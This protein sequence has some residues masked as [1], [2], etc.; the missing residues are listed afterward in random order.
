[1]FGT[2][3]SQHARVELSIL[4]NAR[5]F[6]RMQTCMIENQLVGSLELAECDLVV[7]IYHG[8]AHARLRN[9]EKRQWTLEHSRTS[10]QSTTSRSSEILDFMLR[11]TLAT[12]IRREPWRMPFGPKRALGKS[13]VI[14]VGQR[15]AVYAHLPWP[16]ACTGIE[17]SACTGRNQHSEV[18]GTN[19]HYTKHGNIIRSLRVHPKAS[20]R[21]SSSEG[22]Q[23][24]RLSG[25]RLLECWQ[26]RV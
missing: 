25:P 7:G 17:G 22:S 14:G 10:P 9:A 3:Q 19:G 24:V 6:I 1:M 13:T 21:W 18:A 12:W 11:L 15:R 5:P 2:N 16:V 26:Y 23:A 20:E 4:R 8:C